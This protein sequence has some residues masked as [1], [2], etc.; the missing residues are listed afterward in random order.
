MD[1]HHDASLIGT[2]GLIAILTIKNLLRL[3]GLW[4]VYR[5]ALALYNISPFHPLYRFPGPRLAAASFIYEFWFDFVLLG[6]YSHEIKRMHDIYGPIVRINPEELHCNDPDF[7]EE[8]Y[9]TTGRVRDKQQ[10]YLNTVAG[11]LSQSSF[12]TIDHETPHTAEC[13]E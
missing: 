13:R 11:P 3:L 12:A 9:P 1:S 7:T 4:V 5:L 8:I 2:D 10:H 6:R